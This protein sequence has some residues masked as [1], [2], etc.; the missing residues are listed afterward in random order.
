MLHYASQGATPG[1]PPDGKSAEIFSESALLSL[2][3]TYCEDSVARLYDTLTVARSF[4]SRGPDEG[5][6]HILDITCFATTQFLRI[7]FPR[8][9]VD[10]C[11]KH[12]KWEGFL[13]GVNAKVCDLE[14][15]VLPYE[16]DSFDL[17]V[18]T[19]T[20]EHIPRS[21]YAVLNEVARVLKPGGILVF[22]V[23]NLSSLNNRIKLLLGRNILSVERAHYS[24]FGHFREYNMREVEYMFREL[25]WEVLVTDYIHYSD[26]IPRSPAARRPTTLVRWWLTRFL[27][28]L[29]PSFR[30]ASLAIVRK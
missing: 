13:E 27:C 7:L 11:D 15:S 8:A 16:D 9:T 21:P 5:P 22:S 1:S 28:K 3:E 10:A 29:V 4:L 30:P 25:G 17:V 20:L 14:T 24:T 26:R 2:Y 23:P 18:F 12:L 19:E 6:R